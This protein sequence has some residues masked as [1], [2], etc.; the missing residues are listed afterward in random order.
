MPFL[1]GEMQNA[2]FVIIPLEAAAFQNVRGAGSGVPFAAAI[3]RLQSCWLHDRAPVR[4]ITSSGCDHRDDASFQRNGL[5]FAATP[6]IARRD[7]QGAAEEN[8]QKISSHSSPNLLC[9]SISRTD[10]MAGI[11]IVRSERLAGFGAQYR[12]CLGAAAPAGSC[13]ARK[14]QPCSIWEE[15]TALVA[16]L[17]SG[18]EPL[19]QEAGRSS[20]RHYIAMPGERPLT[21]RCPAA[22]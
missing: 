19:Q 14:A 22:E 10:P 4:V 21:A 17:G 18:H 2:R 12:R 3:A 13:Q 15:H 7:Q 6:P 16:L 1:L 5:T 20:N 9:R 8:T 11:A